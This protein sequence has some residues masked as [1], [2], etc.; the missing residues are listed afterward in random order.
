MGRTEPQ[1][2]VGDSSTPRAAVSGRTRGGRLSPRGDHRAAARLRNADRGAAAPNAAVRPCP[3][4]PGPAAHPPEGSARPGIV[5]VLYLSD[6][7]DTSAFFGASRHK[8]GFRNH[9][10]PQTDGD[11]LKAGPYR[12]GQCPAPVPP[13]RGPA[14]Q[15]EA[16]KDPRA[17]P[18]PP[19]APFLPQPRAAPSSSFAARQLRSRFP[20]G[21]AR[22]AAHPPGPAPT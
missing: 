4:A 12:P 11:I 2:I 8:N 6:T 20:Q 10:A 15:R 18:R 9:S 19:P 16:G 3:A 5:S 1:R 7:N 14:P 21:P 17:G 22:D 13:H